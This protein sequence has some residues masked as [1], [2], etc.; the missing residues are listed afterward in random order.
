M[1]TPAA[2]APRSL[3]TL[4]LVDVACRRGERLLFAGLSTTLAAGELAWL[5]GSNGRGKTSLLRL[6]AGLA[7]PERGRILW[8]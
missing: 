8:D 1:P 5:R 7:A 3:P 2:A 4:E 6:V